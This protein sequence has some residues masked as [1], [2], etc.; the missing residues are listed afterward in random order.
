MSLS[1]LEVPAASPS[2]GLVVLLHGWGA[3]AQDVVDLS[4]A[5]DLSGIAFACPNGPMAHPYSAE[6]RMWYD[7]ESPTWA[8]LEAGRMQ[9]NDWL[10]DCIA[11]SGVPPERVILAG[12]SQGG[13]MT[14]EV[15]LGRSLAGLVVFSGYLHPHLKAMPPEAVT[16]APILVLHGQQDGVVPFEAALDTQSA[17]ISLGANLQFQSFEMGHEISPKALGVAREFVRSILLGTDFSN[18]DMNIYQA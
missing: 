5:L 12:F 3:N 10:D 4:P 13:A 16:S 14:L 9:L 11:S 2:R 18:S 1:A 8:G 7:L 6:G 15:G 17:L